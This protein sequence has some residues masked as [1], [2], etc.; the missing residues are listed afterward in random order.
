VTVS[1]PGGGLSSPATFAINNPTPNIT[2]IAPT[3]AVTGGDPFTLVV[4]GT[5]FVGGSVVRWNGSN[6][7]T[8]FVSNSQISASRPVIL[9]PAEL[10]ASLSS[11]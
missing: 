7:A 6:R 9:P 4:N 1:N 10:Q 5:N 11:I 3:S 8:V 2:S